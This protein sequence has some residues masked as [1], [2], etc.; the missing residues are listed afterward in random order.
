MYIFL[1]VVHVLVC[2]V[3]IAVILLQAG[4]GGGLSE[5]VG[6]QVQNL[7]GTQTNTFM[8][9][10]TE[11]SAIIFIVTSL[12]LGILSTQRGK[13]L[14]EKARVLPSTAASAVTTTASPEGDAK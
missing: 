9:R 14:V 3:L 12:S 10:A 6:G 13:S 2:F 4:R 11:V 8:T 1:I 7:F 5:M